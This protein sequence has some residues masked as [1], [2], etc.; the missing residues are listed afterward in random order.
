M[1]GKQAPAGR[2]ARWEESKGKAEQ[3]VPADDAPSRGNPNGRGPAV[4]RKTATEQDGEA[5]ANKAFARAKG[6][7]NA[8]LGWLVTQENSSG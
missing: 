5:R 8:N 1:R 6:H 2:A 7:R 4:N 3:Q